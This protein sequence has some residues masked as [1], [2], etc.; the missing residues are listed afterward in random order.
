[1]RFLYTSTFLQSLQPFSNSLN[2]TLNSSLVL[3]SEG[4]LDLNFLS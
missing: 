4:D 1:M 2:F 3:F